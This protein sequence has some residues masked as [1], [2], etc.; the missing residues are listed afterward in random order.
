M[1]NCAC[2]RL[3]YLQIVADSVEIWF[4]YIT[5]WLAVWTDFRY[6]PLTKN[7]ILFYDNINEQQQLK[8]F[9]YNFQNI[10]KLE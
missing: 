4:Q 6:Y 9:N 7:L 5:F 10:I 2:V 1:D 8:T 3:D